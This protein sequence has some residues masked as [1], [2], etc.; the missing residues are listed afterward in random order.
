MDDP[1]PPVEGAAR[2]IA[3]ARTPVAAAYLVG[4]DGRRKATIAPPV[5]KAPA[6]RQAAES[7]GGSPGRSWADRASLPR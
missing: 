6:T 2:R 1:E 7:R 5:K 4:A 3:T